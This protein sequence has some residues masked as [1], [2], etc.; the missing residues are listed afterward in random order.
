MGK[1]TA[2]VKGG[3]HAN[4]GSTLDTIGDKITDHFTRRMAQSLSNKGEFALRSVL[5]TVLGAAPG[6]TAAY[7]TA[8]IEASPEMGGK[9][10]IVNT[11]VV[12]RATVAQD[13]TDI[14]NALT[15]A[16][17]SVANPPANLDRNPLGTR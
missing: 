4:Y 15:M 2:A 11:Y 12:N 6:G 7:F 10:N 5:D 8:E 14:R 16:W 3:L 13:V 1:F 17:N 9:R